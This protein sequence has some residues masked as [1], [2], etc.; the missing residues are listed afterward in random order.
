MAGLGGDLAGG[1]VV[2]DL[3]AHAP[4]LARST[5]TYLPTAPR[6]QQHGAHEDPADRPGRHRPRTAAGDADA[7]TTSVGS[8]ATSQ[9][10][11]AFGGTTV[12]RTL[13]ESV[14]AA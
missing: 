6:D 3:V 5:H 8:P 1:G 4:I 10:Q 12:Y 11:M 9:V 2:V 7:T 14:P 13:A